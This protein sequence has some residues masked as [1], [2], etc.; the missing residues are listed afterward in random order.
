[1][2]RKL[3]K[4]KLIAALV[5]IRKEA[6]LTQQQLA[7]KLDKPQSYVS[8]YETGERTLDMIEVIEVLEAIG[9]NPI[10]QIAELYRG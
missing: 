10:D 5:R 2:A 7:K 1:M 4:E 9:V 6:E 8:K 3:T